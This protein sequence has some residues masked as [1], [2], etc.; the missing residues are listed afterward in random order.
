MKTKKNLFI[1]LGVIFFLLIGSAIYVNF[2]AK[3]IQGLTYILLSQIFLGI[4][5]TMVTLFLGGRVMNNK[6]NY[7]ILFL[8]LLQC[9]FVLGIVTMCYVY[10]YNTVLDAD[11]YTKYMEYISM[12]MNINLYMI[13]TF[14]FALLN[15]NLY[16]K[17]KIG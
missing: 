11:N 4:I 3:S 6:K 16:I 9:F 13:F 7:E 5:S 12:N 17:E 1:I 15:F 8:A 10:G 2:F 14:I